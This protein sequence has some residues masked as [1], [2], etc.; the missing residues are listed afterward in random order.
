MRV[1]KDEVVRARPRVE[2][3]VEQALWTD[4]TERDDCQRHMP[5]KGRRN[6]HWIVH[7]N[8]VLDIHLLPDGT[9]VC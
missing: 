9:L 5:Q 4:P 1:S 8:V 3:A 6:T 2:L 7:E